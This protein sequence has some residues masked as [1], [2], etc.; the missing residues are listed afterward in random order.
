M[1]RLSFLLKLSSAVHAAVQREHHIPKGGDR[2]TNTFLTPLYD[3][4]L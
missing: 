1:K 4:Y 3:D 2:L